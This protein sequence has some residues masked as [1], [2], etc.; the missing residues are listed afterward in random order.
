MDAPQSPLIRNPHGFAPG[1]TSIT[2]I[3]EPELD[4]GIEFGILKLVPGQ[5]HES[6]SGDEIALVLLDGEAVFEAEGMRETRSRESLFEGDPVVLHLGP[7]ARGSVTAVTAVELAVLG[8]EGDAAFEPRLFDGRSMRGTE[9]RGIGTLE[10]TAYRLVRTVFDLTNRPDAHVVLGEVV[11][12]PGR[13][14]SYPP[15]HHPHPEICHYRFDHPAGYGHAELGEAV[16][17]VRSFDTLKIVGGED[18]P[19]VAAPG[20]AMYYLWAVRHLPGNPYRGF[21]YADAHRWLADA[22]R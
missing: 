8:V 1:F 12:F 17:K 6:A 10:D 15:H 19:Q 18:H 13:W 5:R 3:G 4:T 9:H 14:S 20:Y 21:A 22:G 7:G 11:N 16:V 2:R